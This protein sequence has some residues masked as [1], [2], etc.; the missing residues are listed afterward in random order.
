MLAS[1]DVAMGGR[2][3]EELILGAENVTS[4]ASSDLQMA[5]KVATNMVVVYGMSDS[6]SISWQLC[7]SIL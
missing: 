4:G 1:I 2:V 5:T 3:A 6:V 7:C